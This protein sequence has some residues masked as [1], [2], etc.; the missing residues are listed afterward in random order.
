[1]DQNK[2]FLTG[3]LSA[4]I[5]GLEV[6]N[7]G[8]FAIVEPFI[9]NLKKEFPNHSIRTSFQL[10][11][12]FEQQKE[13]T[14]LRNERFWNYGKYTAKQTIKDAFKLLLYK[15]SFGS[16][17]KIINSSKL[18]KELYNADFVIDFSGDV[19][20]EN[21]KF[22]VF[23][24]GAAKIFFAYALKKKVFVLAS[25]PGPFKKLYK[26][27][28]VKYLY[29]KSEIILNREPIS[30]DM[31]IELG[32]NKEITKTSACPS[33]L[34]KGNPPSTESG[35][36]NKYGIHNEDKLVGFILTGWTLKYA[37]YNKLP[38]EE[39]ELTIFVEFLIHLYE[40]YEF[41]IVLLSH[42][43]TTLDNGDLVYGN[44]YYILKQLFEMIPE[45]YKDR[46]ILINEVFDAKRAKAFIG[47]FDTLIS[48]RLHG[49]IAG[50]SQTV[51]TIVYDYGHEP[52]AHKLRGF[53]RLINYENFLCNPTDLD[54][55][56]SLFNKLWT[57][58][59]SIKE[60]L[61]EE[62]ASVQSK[63]L[64]NFKSIKKFI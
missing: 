44:D 35:L 29:N 28:I 42:G 34:F 11:E 59:L 4:R 62:V 9:D 23:L 16:S 18:L 52:K 30:T 58:R 61:K 32:L 27:L 45:K 46:I 15:I 39:D 41:K 14:C 43:N 37:P 54:E 47:N 50:I 25:S 57:N 51:P 1:M 13:I 10:S 5:G 60:Q 6:G 36:L 38:R 8:N 64:L 19:F 3:L 21:A 63:A 17:T 20:G 7:L 2:I 12:S 53:L 49:A 33:Y 48:G 55:M 40:T 26:R 24:E 22:N 31:L 56:K